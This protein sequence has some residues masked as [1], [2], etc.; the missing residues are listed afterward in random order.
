[1]SQIPKIVPFS[2]RNII[3]SPKIVPTAQRKIL[4]GKGSRVGQ[5]LTPDPVLQVLRGDLGETL[6]R[7]LQRLRS[8]LGLVESCL[9]E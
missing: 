2:F 4:P 7:E 3:D 8:R 9:R 1:M 5:Q 6:L